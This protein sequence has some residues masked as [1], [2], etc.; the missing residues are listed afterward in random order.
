MNKNTTPPPA[1]LLLDVRAATLLAGT[2]ERTMRRLFDERE[3]PLVRVRRRLYV[4]R[5]DLLAYLDA[6]TIPARQA[7]TK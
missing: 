7:A 1:A 2:T 6:N 5:S 4:R 3:L